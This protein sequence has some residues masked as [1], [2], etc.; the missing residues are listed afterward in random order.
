MKVTFVQSENESLAVEFFSALLKSSGH[1]V[2][3]AYDHRYFARTAVTLPALARAF[4]LRE[5]LVEQIVGG[6]PDMVGFSV[7]TSGYQWAIDMARRIKRA[8]DVP[9]I[10]GGVHVSSVPEVVMSEDAVDIVCVGEGERSFL[11]LIDQFESY[12]DVDIPGIWIK[13]D[14]EIR[15]SEPNQMITDLDSLPFPDKSLFYEKLPWLSR[16]YLIMTSRGC[17]YSCTFCSNDMLRRLLKGKGRYVRRRGVDNVI[18]EMTLARERFH[19]SR[20]N[21]LDDCF[22]ADKAWL[23]EFCARY[24]KDVS[25]PFIAVSHPTM[26]DDEVAA[27]L[28]S[29]RC[30]ILLLGVQSASEATRRE[31][32]NRKET[33]EQIRAAVAACHHHGLKL[34]IDHIFGIPGEGVEEYRRALSFYNEI[35]PDTINTYWLV[36]FPKTT[37]IEHALDA[38]ILDPGDVDLINH[39]ELD[40]AMNIGLGGEGRK[41]SN[42]FFNYA[43]LFSLIPFLPKRAIGFLI[44]RRMY[45]DNWNPPIALTLTLRVL[46]LMKLGLWKVYWETALGILMGFLKSSF[47]IAKRMAIHFISAK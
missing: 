23:R 15:R 30:A 8:C 13:Y 2:D 16:G 20:F 33:N 3:L 24:E 9:I 10:F 19:P 6:K 44:R 45:L 27:M 17:P 31:M 14:G 40:I 32:L 39:G 34:S 36:Y 29:A 47:L 25:V 41:K 28:A 1:A 5:M 22:T 35:R 12:P 42:E 18:E 43:F 4:D 21:I 38:G 7:M 26:V 46:S 11:S 37:I